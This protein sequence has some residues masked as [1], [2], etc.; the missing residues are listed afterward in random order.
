MDWLY[1]LCTK[2]EYTIPSD[3]EKVIIFSDDKKLIDYVIKILDKSVGFSVNTNVEY[4]SKCFYI[5]CCF[6]TLNSFQG[7]SEKYQE[8]LEKVHEI[9]IKHPRVVNDNFLIIYFSNEEITNLPQ[10][11]QTINSSCLLNYVIGAPLVRYSIQKKPT[12][13]FQEK[14]LSLDDYKNLQCEMAEMNNKLN[15]QIVDLRQRVEELEKA[16]GKKSQD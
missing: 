15:S 6:A 8:I 13:I 3:C 9:P 12:P 14:K 1:S 4:S 2:K 7:I 5:F 16:F 11:L 10:S